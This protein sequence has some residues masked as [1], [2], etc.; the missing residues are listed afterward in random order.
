MVALHE[1]C[2]LLER[3]RCRFLGRHQVA[4]ELV[5]LCPAAALQYRTFLRWLRYAVG[6]KVVF[7]AFHVRV[8]LLLSWIE[9]SH[10][11]VHRC[12]SA[13]LSSSVYPRRQCNVRTPLSQSGQTAL[14]NSRPSPGLAALLRRSPWLAALLRAS[15][16]LVTL[17]ALY[18]S[19][20]LLVNSQV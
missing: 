3:V 6:H 4:D 1:F 13:G 20:N 9:L 15:P 8:P 10:T 11:S 18:C 5:C 2:E 16:R 12:H 7:Q 17:Q 14:L 19:L